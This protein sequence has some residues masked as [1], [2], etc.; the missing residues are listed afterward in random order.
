MLSFIFIENLT[1]S[2]VSKLISKVFRNTTI[3]HRRCQ[4]YS[5]HPNIIQ[6]YRGKH[7][8]SNIKAIMIS[9]LKLL[10]Y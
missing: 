2:I 4:K 3:L 10:L 7:D 8:T 1:T 5:D 9:K 6:S